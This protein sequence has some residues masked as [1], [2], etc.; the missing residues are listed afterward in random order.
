MQKVKT[1]GEISKMISSNISIVG[2]QVGTDR[3]SG[4]IRFR[5]DF[6]LQNPV[7]VPVR[8]QIDLPDF[9]R[10]LIK[11]FNSKVFGILFAWNLKK[12]KLVSK[13]I[14]NPTSAAYNPFPTFRNRI[15]T[16]IWNRRTSSMFHTT[17]SPRTSPQTSPRTGPRTGTIPWLVT[18]LELDLVTWPSTSHVTPQ[19][20]F[21]TAVVRDWMLLMFGMLCLHLRTWK[22]GSPQ[23]VYRNPN[24]LLTSFR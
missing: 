17:T 21:N 4:W 11:I 10:N 6:R 7:P 24:N 1:I 14:K 13:K 2:F 18:W 22:P 23:I 16:I 19:F 5:P 3:K 8:F 15:L 9:N 12:V 20:H